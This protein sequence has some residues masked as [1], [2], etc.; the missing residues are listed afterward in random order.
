MY[1][2]QIRLIEQSFLFRR[3]KTE[4]DSFFQYVENVRFN[5]APRFCEAN[6]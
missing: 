1:Q 5:V 2:K 4:P 3:S 6:A